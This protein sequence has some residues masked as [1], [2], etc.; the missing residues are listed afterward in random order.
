MVF[1]WKKHC[2]LCS[3]ILQR[4]GHY[5]NGKQRW[6][7]PSCRQSVSWTNPA[8][9]RAKERE[10][11]RLWITEG[12]SARQLSC[13]SGYSPGKLYRMINYY[14]K[15]TPAWSWQLL[16][17][18]RYFIIDGT[19]LHRPRTLI[20]LMDAQRHSIV[21]GRYPVSESS[22]A[23]LT[24]FLADLMQQGLQPQSFTVD[25]N[26]NVMR[27]L[28]KFWPGVVIQRCLV[29]IQRQG[30]AWCRACPKTAYARQLRKI[31]LGVTS[32]KTKAERKQIPECGLGVGREV[33]SNN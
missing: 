13:R 1:W 24:V 31:F 9:R 12:Y 16:R 30:L 7:C 11:F 20:A 25:G 10:W 2:P 15:E 19:F 6:F 4:N 33:W 18:G 29:H 14:L 8:A 27:T 17:Q 5:S 23:Q 22:E 32:I 3:R 21:T 26:P 28:R